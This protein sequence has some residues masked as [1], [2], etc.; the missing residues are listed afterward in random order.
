MK[1]KLMIKA[2]L[3]KE[4]LNQI[5]KSL[6]GIVVQTRLF[7][8]QDKGKLCHCFSTPIEPFHSHHSQQVWGIGPC[9]PSGMDM[10]P[11]SLKSKP[12]HTNQIGKGLRCQPCSKCHRVRICAIQLTQL[13]S[14]DLKDPLNAVISNDQRQAIGSHLIP[15]CFIHQTNITYK[16]FPLSLCLQNL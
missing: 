2:Y 12:I 13:L 10:R 7:P 15:H 3:N 9:A 1:F 14:S 6:I 4:Y 11:N 8:T 16:V 5:L